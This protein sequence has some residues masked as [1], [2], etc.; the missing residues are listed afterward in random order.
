MEKQDKITKEEMNLVEYPIQFLSFKIPE[1]INTVKWE[2]QVILKNGQKVQSS[3]EIVGSEKYG[4][5]RYKDRDVLLG[6]LYYWHLNNFESPELVIEDVREFLELLRWDTSKFYYEQL[7]QSLNRLSTVTI[8]ARYSF[9]DNEKKDY[10]THIAIHLLDMAQLDKRDN[11]RYILKVRAGKEFWESVKKGY[12][13]S[14]NFDFYLELESPIAKALYSYLDKKSYGKESF[15]IELDKLASHLGITAKQQKH[16]KQSIKE[17][18]EKLIQKGYLS[19]Y[20]FQ[21]RNGTEYVIFDF[22]KGY[23][24]PEFQEHL[25]QNEAY[26][27][28]L[29]EEI[30]RVVGRDNPEYIEKVAR[31]VPPDL[32]FRILGEIK[33]MA[34]NGELRTSRFEAFKKL[35]KKYMKEIFNLSFK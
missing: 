27:Q 32:I 31:N 26:V 5:P 23:L 30:S 9:W 35:V 25:A 20:L 4:L 29:I 15:V 19:C 14:L 7:E 33:E 34:V 8:I 28:H 10:L 6:L 24:E 21:K 11:N 3:W 18:C 17:A 12:L 2:G 13:K 1:G 16:R 22:N